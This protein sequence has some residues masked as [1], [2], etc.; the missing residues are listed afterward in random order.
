MLKFKSI[1]C[2]NGRLPGKAWFAK[3][4]NIP[5]I[6]ADGAS[7][8]LIDRG[9]IPNFIIGDLDSIEKK[10]LANKYN[11]LQIADQNTTD[12]EKCLSKMEEK[13]FF[14]CLVLGI[15]GGEVDHAIYN[16][17]CFMRHAK[18]QELIFLDIDEN[19]KMKYGVPVFERYEIS[20]QKGKT[21]SLL[22]FPE[23]T[24][25][26]NGLKWELTA[27]NLSVTTIASVRNVVQSKLATINVHSGS[28]LLVIDA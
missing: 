24:V 22:P 5:L 7:N 3:Q 12:F 18:E 8:K 17:N 20:E 6:A 15:S 10:H 27:S 14:P 9:I 28:L 23:A 19:H 26:T 21:I 1:L 16:L 2:L 25:S 11:I 13:N 4:Q